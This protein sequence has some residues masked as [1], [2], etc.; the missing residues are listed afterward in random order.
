MRLS[1]SALRIVVLPLVLAIAVFAG[2]V[3]LRIMSDSRSQEA[4]EWEQRAES[5]LLEL[6]AVAGMSS[7]ADLRRATMML[8][9]DPIIEE[10]V[11]VRGEPGV[12]EAASQ[13]EWL[14]RSASAL[15]EEVRERLAAGAGSFLPTFTFDEENHVLAA[16]A[17]LRNLEIAAAPAPL[18]DRTAYVSVDLE[19][20]GS[21][22]GP[23]RNLGLLA[24]V[25]GGILAIGVIAVWLQRAPLLA[26]RRLHRRLSEKNRLL[27]S[28]GHELRTPLTAVTGFARVLQEEWGNLGEDERRE[29]VNVIV[30]QGG[31]LADI[32]EDLLTLGKVEAGMLRV[33]STPV[34]LGAE[35]AGVIEGLG[36]LTDRRIDSPSGSVWAQA[37]P[38]RV[39]Q[40]V[41]NLLT[42]ALKYGGRRISVEPCRV[43]AVAALRVIDDG[44]GVVEA[45]RERIFEPFQRAHASTGEAE[46]LGL[47]LAISREL[48]R[49]MGG[50]LT[51]RYDGGRS[52][53]EFTLP[54]GEPNS[55]P[56]AAL[57]AARALSEG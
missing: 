28:V 44:P 34:D 41:R 6:Q 52:I 11:V 19:A 30:R 3:T 2:V 49:A 40:V 27:S 45:M 15:S 29:M 25:L 14:G 12:V 21:G 33:V 22:L 13:Y 35:A 42:N 47:G 53:F 5:V 24:L 57:P 36:E 1:T 51:Y 48:A 8:A 17:T 38:T 4:A 50:D 7:Q 32:I 43:D 37:D 46:S 31:D 54:A 55:A 9:A 26:N 10:I 16:A 23:G 18:S 39:R 56:T 20:L